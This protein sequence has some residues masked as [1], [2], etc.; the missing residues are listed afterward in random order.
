MFLINNNITH[1]LLN[2]GSGKEITIKELVEKI[3]IVVNFQGEIVFNK[4]YP[5]GNPRKLIDS[6]K[7]N[8]LGWKPTVN[9]EEGLKQTYDWYLRSQ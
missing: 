9:I 8:E 5:D 3:K 2:V 4:D 1:G 7:I 6:S